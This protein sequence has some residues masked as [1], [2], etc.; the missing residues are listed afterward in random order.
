M[1]QIYGPIFILYISSEITLATHKS[2]HTHLMFISS[3]LACPIHLAKSQLHAEH[4][5]DDNKLHKQKLQIVAI[6]IGAHSWTK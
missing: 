2:V 6:M 1:A 5:D 4:Y 3:W